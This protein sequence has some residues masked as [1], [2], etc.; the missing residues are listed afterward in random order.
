MAPK[1][2]YCLVGCRL[3]VCGMDG[4]LNKPSERDPVI[5]ARDHAQPPTCHTGTDEGNTGTCEEG[6]DHKLAQVTLPL[7]NHGCCRKQQKAIDIFLTQQG[8]VA[9]ESPIEECKKRKK[10]G[11]MNSVL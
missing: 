7:G 6:P 8:G 5:S 2:L 1:G 4:Q 11:P 10:A 9:H 3:G